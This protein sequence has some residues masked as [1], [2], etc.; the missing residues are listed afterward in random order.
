MNAKC[1]RL[2]E[3]TAKEIEARV[4]ETLLSAEATAQMEDSKRSQVLRQI[5][6]AFAELPFRLEE[7]LEQLGPLGEGVQGSHDRVEE[8]W[9]Y[10]RAQYVRQAIPRELE[11]ADCADVEAQV[12]LTSQREAVVNLDDSLEEYCEERDHSSEYEYGA[13]RPISGEQISS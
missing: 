6:K 11:L 12:E 1:A 9:P 4:V 5:R 10:V 13:W 2:M 8:V 3:N 7:T